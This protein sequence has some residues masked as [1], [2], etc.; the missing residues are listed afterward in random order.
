MVPITTARSRHE[1]IIVVILVSS[2]S[3]S[4]NSVRRNDVRSRAIVV[5]IVGWHSEITRVVTARIRALT[6]LEKE[7]VATRWTIVYF[8]YGLGFFV[9]RYIVLGGTV[10]DVP[11]VIIHGWLLLWIL[12][13]VIVMVIVTPAIVI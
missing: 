11:I 2:S 13:I 4:V 1:S 3:S 5:V 9:L 6:R 8:I 7:T 10:R 12:L